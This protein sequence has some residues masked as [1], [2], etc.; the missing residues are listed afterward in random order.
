[1]RIVKTDEQL[2]KEL[3]AFAKKFNTEY[4]LF[5]YE[6]GG[7]TNA[8]GDFDIDDNDW[9]NSGSLREEFDTWIVDNDL[10]LPNAHLHIDFEPVKLKIFTLTKE[11][12]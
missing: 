1:M 4:N 5:S 7:Y 12:G 2:L 11:L 3:N 10:N 8:L 9:N 6:D